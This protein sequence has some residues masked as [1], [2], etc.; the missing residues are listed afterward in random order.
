MGD[1]GLAR[2]CERHMFGRDVWETQV[3]QGCVS[4]AGD[5]FGSNVWETQVE[6]VCVYVVGG[7]AG[8]CGR[9]RFGMDVWET[10][11][12][13]ICVCCGRQ[14]WQGCVG[15]IDLAGMCG[16]DRF[17]RDVCQ[18]NGVQQNSL[19]LAYISH[20]LITHTLCIKVPT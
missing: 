17:G 19:L 18:L 5:R 11:L 20:A 14:V 16:R 8:I 12:A 13:G 10:G 4:V 9:H 6:Q 1:I 7:L 3:W 15:G 2:M